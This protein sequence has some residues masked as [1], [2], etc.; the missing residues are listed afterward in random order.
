MSYFSTI[1]DE[2]LS[3]KD[4]LDDALF[5]PLI[6]LIDR[7]PHIF[8][9][10]AGR[11]GL[12]IN[13]FTNRLMHLGYSVSAVGEISSPHSRPGD[14]MIIGSGSGETQRLIHQAQLASANGVQIA[15]MT[16]NADS[17]LANLADCVLT[18]PASDSCQPMGTLFEQTSLL[19]WDSIVLALMA[20]RGE[21]NASM[22]QRHADIE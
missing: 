8:L 20:L 18:L 13:A 10:G 6:T 11:S 12:I 21:N 14:L 17:T 1:L 16:M 22:K 4:A 9:A 5:Q 19:A 15:L 3:Q 7:A 2:L